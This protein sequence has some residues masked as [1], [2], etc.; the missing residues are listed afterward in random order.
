MG[1]IS[2]ERDRGD[3]VYRR[4]IELSGDAA[5]EL[6]GSDIHDDNST[7]PR[8]HDELEE[9]YAT[10]SS[11]DFL[12]LLVESDPWNDLGFGGEAGED[13]QVVATS[14][15]REL[16]LDEDSREA[17]G[18]T[19]VRQGGR[20]IR[21]IGVSGITA[22]VQPDLTYINT[23]SVQ[24][25][26]VDHTND[27]PRTEHDPTIHTSLERE[28]FS[29]ADGRRGSEDGRFRSRLGGEHHDVGVAGDGAITH[30]VLLVSEV[31]ARILERDLP[32][33]RPAQLV[34]GGSAVDPIHTH[35]DAG[36]HSDTPGAE[37]I[38]TGVLP[39]GQDGSSV[40]RQHGFRL[41]HGKAGWNT[42]QPAVDG[43]RED[44]A[45]D[46]EEG[47]PPFRGAHPGSLEHDGGERKSQRGFESTQYTR[48]LTLA[49]FSRTRPN[50]TSNVRTSTR[51]SRGTI[52]DGCS[53]QRFSNPS[54]SCG[55][56]RR[57]TYS[58]QLTTP[59]CLPFAA[60]PRT[61]KRSRQTL[62]QSI[63]VHRTR[64]TSTRP[65]SFCSRSS[66]RS[67][68]TKPKR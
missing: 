18:D 35:S 29:A 27:T 46:T 44:S 9:D 34:R 42:E 28:V 57:S 26:V 32:V 37:S 13:T 10:N 1:P 24:Q 48:C 8:V 51:G 55:E 61:Q 25:G 38:R 49:P 6:P 63:G 36:S 23:G 65:G 66:R 16:G 5:A 68:Q 59:S 20:G 17:F 67:R 22:R 33:R 40:D 7:V 56:N 31:T 60:G 64:F 45:L 4:R 15:Q 14:T 50:R 47:H 21:D 52:P 2:G 19:A 11:P 58:L 30:G 12:R 54:R 53:N 62:S 3:N 41:L 39:S 43:D